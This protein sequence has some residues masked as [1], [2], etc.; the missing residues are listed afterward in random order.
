MG[1]GWIEQQ[2]VDSAVYDLKWTLR[3]SDIEF[4][5]TEPFQVHNCCLSVPGACC[6]SPPAAHA[7]SLTLGDISS[8]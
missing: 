7:Q 8:L 3:R 4:D 2:D 6:L 1:R 5:K